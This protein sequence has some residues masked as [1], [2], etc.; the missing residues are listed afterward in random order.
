[1]NLPSIAALHRVKEP[2][3][4]K[5]RKIKSRAASLRH[6]YESVSVGAETNLTP[7]MRSAPPSHL[8]KN[9]FPWAESGVSYELLTLNVSD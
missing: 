1:M 8:H 5:R 2:K 3:K 7:P 9:R 6:D 4:K